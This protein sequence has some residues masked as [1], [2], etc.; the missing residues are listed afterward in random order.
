MEKVNSTL[1]HL[2]C[3][4]KAPFSSHLSFS[5]P[6]V[7]S[8]PCLHAF[9]QHC[10]FPTALSLS[11]HTPTPPQDFCSFEVTEALLICI[12]GFMMYNS[13]CSWLKFKTITYSD[14]QNIIQIILSNESPRK[15]IKKGTKRKWWR[16]QMGYLILYSLCLHFQ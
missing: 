10:N 7:R 1:I 6:R 4:T 14:C 8:F 11:S 2:F 12:S 3:K 9:N 13:Y 15:G 16:E 5:V